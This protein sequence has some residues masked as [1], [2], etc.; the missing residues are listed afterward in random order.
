MGGEEGF[1][2]YQ[3]PW[4]GGG[5]GREKAKKLKIKVKSVDK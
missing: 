3:S 2:C 5:T 4:I 1:G